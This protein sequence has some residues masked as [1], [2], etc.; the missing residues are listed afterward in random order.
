MALSDAEYEAELRKHSSCPDP[1][2]LLR[3]PYSAPGGSGTSVRLLIGF[4]G[5]GSKLYGY[6]TVEDNGTARCRI[7]DESGNIIDQDALTQC[8]LSEPFTTVNGKGVGS[9]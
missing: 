3:E 4:N 8:L 7:I 1:A 9:Q 2:K 6:A 5:K